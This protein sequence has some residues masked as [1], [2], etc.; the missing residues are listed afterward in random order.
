MKW[1]YLQVYL[2]DEGVYVAFDGNSICD[3]DSNLIVLLN[4]LGDDRWE[5]CACAVE[6][7]LYHLLKRTPK[8]I[9]RIAKWDTTTWEAI[10][11]LSDE[12]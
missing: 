12:S 7:K 1:E 9:N 10:E 5:Y 11:R 6:D 3:G 2:N 4:R 8:N